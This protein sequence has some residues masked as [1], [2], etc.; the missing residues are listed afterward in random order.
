M[1]GVWGNWRQAPPETSHQC[2]F[3]LREVLH[4]SGDTRIVTEAHTVAKDC[5]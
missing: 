1:P 4:A 5:K 2:A 3:A